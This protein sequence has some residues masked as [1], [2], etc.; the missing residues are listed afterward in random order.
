MRNVGRTLIILILVG[1]LGACGSTIEVA[2][3][4]PLATVAPTATPSPT[5]APTNTPLPP[6][7]TTAP[8]ATPAAA[9]TPTP[10]L[11]TS[12]PTATK[13][14][15]TKAV[16]TSTVKATA[17]AS[18]TKGSSGQ[19]GVGTEETGTCQVPLPAN[20]TQFLGEDGVWTDNTGLLILTTVA[21]NGQNFTD[22]SATVATLLTTDDSMKN[23]KLSNTESTPTRYRTDFTADADPSN[24]IIPYA[25]HGTLVAVP[26][27]ADNVCA[28]ELIY[29]QGQED[30]YKTATTTVV[31]GLKALKH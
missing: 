23:V 10:Q 14:A 2:T 12:V 3:A 5:A 30:D 26:A 21:T 24:A 19:P 7:A 17:A 18:A 6:T 29:P 25:S 28:A 9:S 27:T 1:L 11:A 22:W 13:P 4:P 31:N 15:A 20:F 16:A 8:T